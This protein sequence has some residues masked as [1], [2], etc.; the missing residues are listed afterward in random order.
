MQEDS[1]WD[2]VEEEHPRLLIVDDSE[3]NRA[4]LANILNPAMKFRRPKTERK[5]LPSFFP[6][7]IASAPFCWMWSC[8]K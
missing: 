3:L 6:E 8:L 1:N 2:V 5:G 7:E 4:L